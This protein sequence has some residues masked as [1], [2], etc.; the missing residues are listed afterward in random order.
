LLAALA[1]TPDPVAP[2]DPVVEPPRLLL[3][4]H[5]STL[6]IVEG[7]GPVSLN[8]SVVGELAQPIDVDTAA[9][10]R[11]VRVLPEH[12]VIDDARKG[13][14]MDLVP[15]DD[16]DASNVSTEIV[17]AT[18]I[19]ER[20][21]EVTVVDDDAVNVVVP[22]AVEIR[23]GGERVLDV[24]L[25]AQP[26]G[27][28]DLVLSVD[29]PAKIAVEPGSL[30]FDE[31]NWTATQPVRVRALVDPNLVE[32]LA[33]VSFTG[34]A[35]PAVVEVR[36]PDD[37]GQALI[38]SRGSLHLDE[39]ET[40]TFEVRLDKEPVSIVE[41]DLASLDPSV[42]AFELPKVTFTPADYD[43]PKTVSVR[44]VEDSNLV[45]DAA[46]LKLSSPYFGTVSVEAM[47][48][49]T[50]EQAI[51]ATT[52]SVSVV[53]NASVELGVSL[54]F[55]P[56]GVA[57]VSVH[58]SDDTAF[59]AN[60]ATI[61]FSAQ[62]WDVPQTVIVT[63]RDDADVGDEPV[64]VSFSAPESKP[65]TVPILVVDDDA[66]AIE[67]DSGYVSVLEGSSSPL[68]IRLVHQPVQPV[69]VS[70][71]AM[72]EWVAIDPPSVT[73]TPDNYGSFR[74]I[75][76]IGVEDADDFENIVEVQV[77]MPGAPPQSVEVHVVEN[78]AQGVVLDVPR[79]E[80]GENGSATFGVS[81]RFRPIGPMVIQIQAGAGLSVTPSTL[82]FDYFGS[83]TPQSVTITTG[84]DA[85]AFDEMTA[86]V[87]NAAGMQPSMFEVEV[88]D[89]DAQA[90]LP[91]ASMFVASEGGIEGLMVSLAFDPVVPVT[92]AAQSSDPTIAIV[93]SGPLVFDSSNYDVP[94][95]VYV[96]GTPDLDLFDAYATITIAGAGAVADVVV[97]VEDDD[98]QSVLVDRT[99][100]SLGE[101]T[102]EVLG[103]ALSF[104][105]PSDAVVTLTSSDPKITF[106]PPTLTFTPGNFAVAQTVVVSAAQDADVADDVATLT[107]WTPG[108]ATTAVTV[109]IADDDVGP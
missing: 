59:A 104:P 16:A 88:T 100:L 41:V 77:T 78:D 43:Q 54:A 4:P 14:T 85:N 40:V 19:G 93:V 34:A 12:G 91:E 33:H 87:F 36:M 52:A 83:R 65:L 18:P 72:E 7:A 62:N 76:L 21:F 28:V 2:P 82:T 58:V 98:Y 92:L 63:G 96:S 79:L 15:Q 99:Q 51:L 57:E 103:V 90:I 53:E 84:D 74:T 50:S 61:V 55:I 95:A 97:A 26:E 5:P 67:V 86:I 46:M 10:D 94:Q 89:D 56:V 71:V 27:V 39:C 108:S 101:G 60:P 106:S 30:R 49:D 80:V 109:S 107:L 6:V 69:T 37:D 31:R 29:D 1:C 8:V 20:R 17:I 66:Q 64:S 22:D 81:M 32:D 47:V 9:R 70:L 38:S 23:E 11:T 35:S 13:F 25:A 3:S 42:A 44:G 48:I 45:A 73:F 68:S 105:P 75:D 24:R 102:S